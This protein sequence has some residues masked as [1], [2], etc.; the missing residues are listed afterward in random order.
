MLKKEVYVF[1]GSIIG[2]C[3]GLGFNFMIKLLM[4]FDF[5][6]YYTQ[7]ETINNFCEKYTTKNIVELLIILLIL[8]PAILFVV[9]E[10]NR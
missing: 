6:P 9:K 5:S 10:R 4:S 8:I 1:I 2:F 7:I 3:L